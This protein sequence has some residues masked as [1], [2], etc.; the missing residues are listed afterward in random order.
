ML[1]TAKLH[2]VG[3]YGAHQDEAV[4]GTGGKYAFCDLQWTQSDRHK[5][6]TDHS[7]YRGAQCTLSTHIKTGDCFGVVLISGQNAARLEGGEG[8]RT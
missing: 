2:V 1:Q 4:F 3:S 8:K 6:V 7:Q 5:V